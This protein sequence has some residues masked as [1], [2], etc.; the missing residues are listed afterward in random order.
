MTWH[1]LR[2]VI[3]G[4]LPPPAGGMSD[5][6]IQLSELLRQEG[7]LVDVVQTN[8]PYRPAWVGSIRGLRALVRLVPYAVAL[9]RAARAADVFHVMANSGWAWHLF[10]TP[11]IWVA[12][13]RDVPCIVVY[14]GGEADAF[15][16]R[17]ASLVAPTLRSASVL[18]V[19]SGYLQRVFEAHGL[20]SRI[21]PNVVDLSLFRPGAARLSG[22]PHVVV[23]RNLEP[24]YDIP[25][26]LRAFAQIRQRTVGA[27]MTIAGSGSERDPLARM[28]DELGLEGAVRFAG[29]LSRD[30]MAEL[31][32]RADLMLNPS[33]VD[34]M[35]VSILEAM[36]SGVPVVSTR[37]GGIP[38]LLDDERTA[39]LVEARNPSA[40]ADAASRLLRDKALAQRIRDAAAADVRQYAWPRVRGLFAA[41]YDEVLGEA[42]HGRT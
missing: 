40:M 9:W 28:A 6:V 41:V 12:R 4:P 13:L 19:P 18:V 24:L 5:Q 37:V 23:A 30:E 39:L 36:A 3:V 26:A 7:A 25:T 35:P 1:Q 42:R 8:P 16:S 22:A 15:L 17:S 2:V 31:L 32:A 10:A 20:K 14:H 11:A 33:T 27:T 34:N 29:R 21:V 38:Y